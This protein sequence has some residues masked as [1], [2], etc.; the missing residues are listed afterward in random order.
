MLS[1]KSVS[2]KK[3]CNVVLKPSKREKITFPKEFIF[4]FIPYFVGAIFSKKCQMWGFRKKD[5]KEGLYRGL[6]VK[7]WR[8]KLAAHHLRSM[9]GVYSEA[10][11][12][13]KKE[14]FTRIVNSF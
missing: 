4:G 3:G 14:L 13:S 1:K 2:Y 5:K 6:F 12:T 8:F 7:K 9:P 11:H 10:S